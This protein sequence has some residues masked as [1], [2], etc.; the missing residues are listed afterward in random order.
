MPLQPSGVPS[1]G[2][3]QAAIDEAVD[4]HADLNDPDGLHYDSGWVI[5]PLGSGYTASGETPMIR[6]IGKQV[7][8]RG[9][10]SGSV[11][12]AMGNTVVATVP[13]GFVPSTLTMYALA[14]NSSSISG[15]LWV[16]SAGGVTISVASTVSNFSVAQQY[17]LD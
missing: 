12:N 11:T 10:I 6:R 2:A 13:A 5:L 16:S 15:R 14:T 8:I 1:R 7:Q 3:I 17:W 4:N 9:R